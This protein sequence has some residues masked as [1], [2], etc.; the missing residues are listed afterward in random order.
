[1]TSMVFMGFYYDIFTT[2]FGRQT[3]LCGSIP[4]IL[5]CENLH[6]TRTDLFSFPLIPYSSANDL[7]FSPFSTHSFQTNI[8]AESVSK[9]VCFNMPLKALK[10]VHTVRSGTGG[11]ASC[12]RRHCYLHQGGYVYSSLFVCLLATLCTNFRTDLHAIFTEGWQWA[13]EQ[14]VKFGWQSYHRLDT[15]IVFRI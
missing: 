9:P 10:A 5:L 11:L 15:G 6:I 7:E 2:P 12:E 13:N 14:M 4:I 1:M 3:S 8:R